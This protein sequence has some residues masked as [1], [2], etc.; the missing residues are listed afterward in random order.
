[1][2]TTEVIVR[3]HLNHIQCPGTRKCIHFNKLCNGAK[4]CADGFDEG[5]HCR[6]CWPYF[7]TLNRWRGWERNMNQGLQRSLE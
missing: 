5:V 4:D 3:C 6:V 7:L 2:G 1:M